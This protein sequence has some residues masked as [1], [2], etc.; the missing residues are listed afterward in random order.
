M[1]PQEL[2]EACAAQQWS[3]DPASQALGIRLVKIAPGEAVFDMRVTGDMVNGHGTCHGGFIFSLADS[4]F[5]FA[6]NSRNQRVVAAHC[7]ISYLNPA[8]LDDVLTAKAVERSRL[9]RSDI[10]DVT[11]TKNDGTVIAEFRGHGRTVKGFI[12]EAL[13]S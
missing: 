7:D 1:T 4:A 13:A 6:A 5:A 9:E 3:D 8:Q 10:V 2:A 12:C 11:V